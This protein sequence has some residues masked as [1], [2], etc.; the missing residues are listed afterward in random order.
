MENIKCIYCGRS[1]A[2]GIELSV[3]DIIPDGLTNKKITNKNVC[4]VDHNNKFSDEFEGHVVNRLEFLRN[5]LG[6]RNKKG[7]LPQYTAEYEI[8]GVLFTKKLA[9]KKEFYSG[10]IIP[11]KSE[12]GK[13]LL[14]DLK[15]LEKL[16]NFNKDKFREV[17]LQKVTQ[18]INLDLSLFFSIEMKRLAAKIGYEW[19]CKVENINDKMQEFEDIISYVLGVNQDNTIVTVITDVEMYNMLNDQMELGSH[20]LTIYDDPDGFTYVVFMFFGLVMYKIRIKKGDNN[21]SEW[22]KIPFYGIRYDGSVIHPLWTMMNVKA[23]LQSIIA[24]DAIKML[25][26]FIINNFTELMSMQIFTLRNF[27]ST[28]QE[29]SIAVTS[30]TGDELYN[31]LLGY[32][33]ERT[34]YTVFVLSRLGQHY[35]SY[36]FG[37][38]FNTNLKIILETEEKVVF[39]KD[40]LF[41]LLFG[42]YKLGKLMAPLE[43]GI[44]IFMN[45]YQKE[46][47]EPK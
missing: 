10:N 1:E 20:S 29:V 24:E 14:G 21:V 26:R 44:E 46:V 16:S 5:Y 35:E 17:S 18:R 2:D 12:S 42:E 32:K 41:D 3:S 8:D 9:M 30:K 23:K 11:G 40:G 38:D 27:Y 7:R 25:K 19:F 31:D 43:K 28:V 34:L 13:L 15:K 36:D 45:A 22:Q 33:S 39:K 6:I 47:L 37:K 4:R